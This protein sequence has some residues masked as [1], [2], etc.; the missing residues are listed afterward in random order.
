MKPLLAALALSTALWAPS[1]ARAAPPLVLAVGGEPEG[2]FDPI[3]GWGRYGNPLFQATLLRL[4][5]DL[6]VVGD[7]ATEWTLSDDRLTWT[8]TLRTDAKFSDGT[9]LTAEDVAF[10]FNT[11]RDAGG[12]ADLKVLKEARAVASDQVQITLKQPQIT[13]IGHLIAMG[14]VPM[15]S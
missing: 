4:D 8:V 13:F 7:L 3:M 9:P 11:A 12:L 15:A 1:L 10:T 5:A 14:I 2:G 6:N